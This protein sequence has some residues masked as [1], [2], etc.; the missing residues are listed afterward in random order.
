MITVAKT[1]SGS[2]KSSFN[3]TWIE[4]TIPLPSSYGSAG[5]TAPIVAS[6]TPDPG[7]WQG[8]WWQVQYNV[9]GGND[10]TTWSVNVNGNPVHLVPIN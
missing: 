4:I 5:G 7:L 1:V 6:G 2:T 8:G 10:T 9:S 3:N